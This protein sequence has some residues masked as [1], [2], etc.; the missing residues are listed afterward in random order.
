MY[1]QHQCNSYPLRLSICLI[2]YCRIDRMYC[3]YSML[4]LLPAA[5]FFTIYFVMKGT[6]GVIP[7]TVLQLS[8]LYNFTMPA[9][10]IYPGVF[11]Y[12]G[13]TFELYVLYILLRKQNSSSLAIAAGGSILLQAVTIAYFGPQSSEWSWVRHNFLGWCHVFIFGM[14]AA[15]SKIETLLPDNTLYLLFCAI[16]CIA[17]LPVALL[18][19]WCWLLFVPY[20]ALHFFVF[21]AGAVKRSLLLHK[22]GMWLGSYSAFI[23]VGHPIARLLIMRFC[24]HVN[25]PLWLVTAIYLIL[26][27]L[28]A[29]AYKPIYLWLMSRDY[30]KIFRW[31]L[32]Y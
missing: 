11:W 26:F 27:L 6:W 29:L 15:K 25:I 13:L 1:K 32:E 24:G 7:K 8:L 14:I 19:M 31:K 28:I 4:L 21:W 17:L 9:L 10:T 23:F 16:V 18:N 12:F 3:T 2:R 5:S 22:I 30:T 20:L